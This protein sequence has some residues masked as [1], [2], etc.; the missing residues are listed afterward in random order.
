MIVFVDSATENPMEV[1]SRAAGCCYGKKDVS[2]SRVISCLNSG[3]LSVFEHASAT[4]CVEGISRACT[5]Q[6]VRHRVASYS[7]QSQRYCKIDVEKN[8]WYVT[9]PR[10]ERT[11]GYEEAMRAAARSYK[12]ALEDGVK[13]EDARYM[14]PNACKTDIFVTMNFREFMHFLDLRDT[15]QAQWEIRELAQEMEGALA[16]VNSEW[17]TLFNIYHEKRC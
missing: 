1:I 7:Q 13:P 3:H 9:P 4:W 10:L 6:L 16:V 15:P 8:D 2:E 12:S 11:T 5:H 17:Y 14:L